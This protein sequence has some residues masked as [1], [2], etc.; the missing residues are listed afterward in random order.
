MLCN[1]SAMESRAEPLG[2]P[3]AGVGVELRSGE[4]RDPMADVSLPRDRRFEPVDLD[5]QVV[6]VERGK[7]EDRES[8]V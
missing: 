7:H 5:E 2:T 8:V 6:G 3:R 4:L 1:G